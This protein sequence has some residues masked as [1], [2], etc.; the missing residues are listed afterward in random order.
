MTARFT[1]NLTILIIGASLAA[2]RFSFDADAVRWVAFGAGASTVVI[3]AAAFLAYGRGPMQ[4]ALDV[5]MA[6]TAGWAVVSALTFA[7]AVIGWLAVG[8][9]GA[10][11]SLAV[12]GLIA[13][14]A[15]MERALWPR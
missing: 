9:G 4:R 3:V 10:L 14:E 2:A 11:A 12:V 1:S 5:G 7:P 8:E 13:H 15:L 6:L